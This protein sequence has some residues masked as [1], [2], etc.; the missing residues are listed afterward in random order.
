VYGPQVRVLLQGLQQGLPRRP[1]MA[2]ERAC[3]GSSGRRHGGP[4]HVWTFFAGRVFLFC[5][6]RVLREDGGAGPSLSS[7]Y[8]GS[9]S[10]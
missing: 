7:R 2:R 3:D 5:R 4:P 1:D 10:I 8:T 6:R 9:G